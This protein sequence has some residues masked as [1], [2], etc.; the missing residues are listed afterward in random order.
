LLLG[1][2][3]LL[4]LGLCLFS[5]QSCKSQS[6]ELFIKSIS[7]FSLKYLAEFYFSFNRQTCFIYE[8]EDE[9]AFPYRIKDVTLWL[10]TQVFHHVGYATSFG[11]S[12]LLMC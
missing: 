5:L 2:D 1:L 9:D 10:V 4:L 7:K 3:L 6:I 8:L 11:L 12:S